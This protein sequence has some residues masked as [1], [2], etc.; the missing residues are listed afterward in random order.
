MKSTSATVYSLALFFSSAIATTYPITG[1]GVNCRS[2]PGTSFSSMKTY[3]KDTKVTLKCQTTG[4]SIDGDSLWD[5]TSDGCYVADYYVKTGTTGY[6]TSKC[7][8]GGGGCPAPK[9]NSATVNLI[10]QYE[11][12][13]NHV[14]KGIL[15]RTKIFQDTKGGI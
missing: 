14:C 5:E 15:L 7:S 11:G 9:S 1:D 2:G 13:V 12:F 4:T 6:V 10:A 8:G 3:A